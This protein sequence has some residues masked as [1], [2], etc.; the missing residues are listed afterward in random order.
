MSLTK[1]LWSE[2]EECC[3]SSSDLDVSDQDESADTRD[4]EKRFAEDI[5]SFGGDEDCTDGFFS[6]MDS[7]AFEEEEE[8]ILSL[9]LQ[10]IKGMANS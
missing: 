9:E 6:H 4:G 3:T 10:N 2:D 1:A 7:D 8:I 5:S